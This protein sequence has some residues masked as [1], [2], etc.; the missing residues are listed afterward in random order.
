MIICDENIDVAQVFLLRSWG[1][2]TKQIGPD[3]ARKGIS[4]PQMV[5]LLHGGTR[6]MLV[7][8]DGAFYRAS[9][10]HSKYCILVLDVQRDEVAASVMRFLSTP[11]FRTQ[12]SR[13]GTVAR[14]SPNGIAI[15]AAQG[16]CRV[17]H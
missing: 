9:L 12:R 7:T 3:I 14:V 16:F 1:A 17:P 13:L 10:C 4:D 5:S 2:R 8:R 11:H 15:L 6:W